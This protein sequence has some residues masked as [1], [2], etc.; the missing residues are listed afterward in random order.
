MYYQYFVLVAGFMRGVGVCSMAILVLCMACMRGGEKMSD[1]EGM[2]G[3][4]N[5]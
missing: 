2:R 5:E 1:A 4:E 3:G